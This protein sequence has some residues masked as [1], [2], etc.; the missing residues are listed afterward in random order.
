MEIKNTYKVYTTILEMLT[1]RGYKTPENVSFDEFIAIYENNI[2]DIMDLDK[3]IY[4]TFYR[5]IKSFAKKDL[6][7]TVQS[8]KEH[9]KNENIN[10]IIV[11]K[12]KY[13]V[14]LNTELT[15]DPYRNVELF[16]FKELINNPT[17]HYLVPK[18]IPLND[19]ETTEILERYQCTKSQ[20]PKVQTIDP[21]SKYFRM[22]PGMVFKI[23][24]SSP[25]AAQYITYRLVR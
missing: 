3:K 24:R 1:D 4:I 7:N 20:L 10:I 23:I 5:E 21:I 8:I 16:I 11:L 25:S 14:A 12:D 9:L 6:E 2:L 13:N 15:N 17:H 18:H 22:R 19:I